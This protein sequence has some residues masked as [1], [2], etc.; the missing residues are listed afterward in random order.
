MEE[1]LDCS[2]VAAGE[3]SVT[4]EDFAG[5][6]LRIERRAAILLV[7]HGLKPVDGFAVQLF[8][9]GDMGHGDARRGTAPVLLT[10]QA[11]NLSLDNTCRLVC[12][13][14]YDRNYRRKS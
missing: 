7:R 2:F 8:L 9:D 11:L 10:G 14:C 4:A 6:Q 5:M 13:F 3:M 12:N 1:T